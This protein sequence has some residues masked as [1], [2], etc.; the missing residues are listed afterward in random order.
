MKI[1]ILRF[2][3]LIFIFFLFLTI[4][5]IVNGQEES[6]VLMDPSPDCIVSEALVNLTWSSTIIGSPDYYVLRKIE[7]EPDEN[8]QEVGTTQELYYVD[9]PVDS[10]KNY[11]YRIRAERAPDTFLSNTS[12]ASAAYCP[13]G[14][15]PPTTSCQA[16]GPHIHLSWSPISGDLLIYEVYRDGLKIYSTTT[17][18]YD[19]GPDIAGTISYDYFVRAVWQSGVSRDSEIVPQ[20]APACPPTL[21]PISLTCISNGPPGGAQIGLSWNELLGVQN[22]QIYRKALTETEFSLLQTLTETSYDDK[23]VESLPD[24]YYQA[25]TISYYVKAI[26]ATEQKDSASRQTNIPRCQ[27]YLEVESNCD[28]FSMRLFW[29]ATLGAIHYNIDRNGEHYDQALG[30]TNTSYVD[31]LDED[32]CPGQICTHTYGVEAIVPALD[33]FVSNWVTKGIDCA[34]VEPPQPAPIL[35]PAEVLCVGGD[36]QIRISWSASDNVTYYSLYRSGKVDP[37]DLIETSYSDSGVEIGY[38]YTYYV[39][40]RGK[41]GTSTISENNQ[42]VTAIDCT[43]PPTPI[44]NLTTG[45]Q[46]GGPFTDLSWS[47]TT[48][49]FSYEIHRGP[50]STELSLLITFDQ[51]SP[52]FSSRTWKDTSVSTSTS[53]YYKVIANGPEGVAPSGSDVKSVSTPSCLPT[54]PILSLD[55]TCEGGQPVINLSWITDEANT[56]RYEILREDWTE[57]INI[58]DISVKSWQDNTVSPATTYNYKVEAVG[59]L[60]IRST[61]GYKSII[62]YD[63]GPPGSFTL[64]EPTVYCQSSYPWADLSW[65]DSSDALSYDPYR[66]LL[67][68]DD[69]IA[70]TTTFS[71]LTSPFTDR[72]F[73]NTLHFDGGDYIKV[74]DSDSLDITDQITAEAWIKLD[75]LLGWQCILYKSW[76]GLYFEQSNGILYNY[77]NISTADPV[78]ETGKW[79]HVAYTSKASKTRLYVNGQ[80]IKE[81]TSTFPGTN[82]TNDLSIGAYSSGYERFRGTIDEVRIYN[83]FLESPE[84]QEHYLGVYNNETGLRGLWHFDEGAGQIVSDSSNFR[85][86]GTLGNNTTVETYDPSWIASGLQIDTK[87]SWQVEA[88]GAGATTFSNTTNPALMPICSPTKPGLVLIPL[89]QEGVSVVELF[90]SFSAHSVSYE[91]YRQDKGLIGTV[92]QAVDPSLRTLVDA[93]V[94]LTTDY[95]YWIKAIGPTGLTAESDYLDVTT[96]ECLPPAQPQNLTL[97]FLCSDSYPQVTLNWDASENTDYY[98]VYRNGSLLVNTEDTTYTDAYPSVEVDTYY[99]YYVIAYGPGGASDPSETQGIRTGYCLPSTP[100]I[101]LLTTD[102]QSLSPINNISWSDDIPFNTTDYKIYRNT[103]DVPPADPIA[104]T[105][106]TNWQDNSGLSPLTIYYYWIGALG[107]AGEGS[108]S[109]SKSIETYGCGLIPPP[110]SLDVTTACCGN[111]PCNTLTWTD[112]ENAYSYNIYR[113]NPDNSTSIYSTRLS[114]FIDKGSFALE[115]DGNNDY[116]QIPISE[117]LKPSNAISIEAWIYPDFPSSGW[118]YMGIIDYLTGYYYNKLYIYYSNNVGYIGGTLKIGGSY[119]SHPGP[120]IPNNDWS[121]ITLVYDGTQLIWYLNGNPEIPSSRSGTIEKSIFPIRIGRYSNR[122]F[123][124]KIDEFRI[125]GRALSATEIQNHYQGIYENETNLRGVWHFD[126]GEGQIVSDSSSFGNNGTRGGSTANEDSDPTWIL[127]SDQPGSLYV[128]SLENEKVYEY[129]VKAFGPDTESSPSNEVPVITSSCLP[130]K[131]V[132][133]ITRQCQGDSSQLLLSWDLDPS[134]LTDYWGLY[135]KRE[136]EPIFTHLCDISPPTNS[137]LDDNVESGVNYEYY[138][139]AWGMGEYTDSDIFSEEA[140]F[141]YE[142]PSKPVITATAQ[143]YGYSSR[144]GIEWEIDPTGNTISYNIW[145]KNTTLGETEFSQIYTGLSATVTEFVDYL[146]IIEE[147]NYIYQVEAVGSGE[148]NTVFSDPSNEI[149]ALGCSSLPPEPPI[150]SLDFY[151]STGDMVAVSLF[152]TDAGT[153]EYYKLFRGP[154]EIAQLPGEDSPEAIIHYVDYLVEDGQ[155]YEYQVLAYNI[156]APEGVSSN[157]VAILIP[158]AIPGEF[159]LSTSWV[160]AMAIHLTWTEAATTEAGGPVTYDVYRDNSIAFDTTDICT[161]VCEELICDKPLECYD[162]S[163]S[164]LES[165]YKVV[166]SNNGGTS[167]SNIPGVTL[168]IPIW[169]EI[170]PW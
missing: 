14:L 151:I 56:T 98:T 41:G 113:T 40:A 45:C 100:S 75:S 57:P 46:E 70:E 77:P 94:S 15:L 50:S 35:E 111:L 31:W 60:D 78:F 62:S 125:Y 44:L 120:I 25:G 10:D 168:P 52:E 119:A 106:L 2:T 96:L 162:N 76:R 80:L 104:T 101:T 136:G 72:G 53:Y 138:L 123:K 38:E 103:S 30:I 61:E 34:T 137:Y 108:L 131:P 65:T 154:D 36:S 124:R 66:N 26:W 152:W 4:S 141:C 92:A 24:T 129:E 27:P 153:E 161:V 19:D 156:N 16:N 86:N 48:N 143:C 84:I 39:I 43:P 122:Y 146:G 23:L 147:N 135:K 47:E 159:T 3:F 130:A 167:E 37:F 7:G 110:P 67:N 32:S 107:P 132:L 33:P 128:D 126:E 149:T 169:T 49:T 20:E 105:T 88:I 22:Y 13:P 85:N 155:Y 127:S 114:S 133:T 116:V 121:H 99:P 97:S 148:E 157:I 69:S 164:R 1:K 6:V 95:T 115:F 9:S 81:N 134:G 109:T 68:P 12:L 83:R 112:S 58:Y 158:I 145:R 11:I 165:Y 82:N 71:N 17:T 18:N 42:T 73:G 140:P 89:C 54:M 74:P 118:G 79:Y 117:S 150:A 102:C 93:D 144:I 51:G 59:Y 160:D 8:Y 28:E 63:C 139:T 5:S 142:L 91:I 166:A 21:N 64:N 55:R 170:A 29:T 90:W 87:Y 163:P